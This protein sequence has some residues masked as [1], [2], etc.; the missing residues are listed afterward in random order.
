[1][2]L[3]ELN[4]CCYYHNYLQLLLVIICCVF[5]CFLWHCG[6][7]ANLLCLLRQLAASNRLSIA[8]IASMACLLTCVVVRYVCVS[9]AGVCVCVYITHLLVFGVN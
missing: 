3:I 1:M 4:Y 8:V 5:N 7:L 6:V 9:A 2:F